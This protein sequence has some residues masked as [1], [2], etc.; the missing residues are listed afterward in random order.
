MWNVKVSFKPTSSCT[1]LVKHPSEMITVHREVRHSSFK[2]Q[3]ERL[4]ET[5]QRIDKCASIVF[6]GLAIKGVKAENYDAI[7]WKLTAVNLIFDR[8][9]GRLSWSWRERQKDGEEQIKEGGGREWGWRVTGLERPSVLLLTI[10]KCL[11][12]SNQM[13]GSAMRQ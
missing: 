10:Q 12:E 11:E 4:S 2:P 8:A 9:R 1:V 13:W 3:I 5:S 6:I 7:M